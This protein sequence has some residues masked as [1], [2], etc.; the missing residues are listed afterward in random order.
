MSDQP[1]ALLQTIALAEELWDPTGVALWLLSRSQMLEEERPI[2][3][4]QRGDGEKVVRALEGL[5]SEA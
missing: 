2:D 1:S 3:L 5:V 4:I